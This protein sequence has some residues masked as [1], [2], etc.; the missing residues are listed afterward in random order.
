MSTEPNILVERHTIN[1]CTGMLPLLSAL[2][3][4]NL[5]CSQILFSHLVVNRPLLLKFFH[6]G[7]YLCF[8]KELI[9]TEPNEGHD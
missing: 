4:L 9:D 8:P 3:S 2:L 7:A 1:L 6:C 5:N